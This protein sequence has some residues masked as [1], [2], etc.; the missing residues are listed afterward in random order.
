[1]VQILKE[2]FK[3]DT[4]A[5]GMAAQALAESEQITNNGQIKGQVILTQAEY[6]ALPSTKETDG[7]IY[8]IRG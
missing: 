7:K 1:M 3:M 8:M 2:A 4:I 6:D 5:R